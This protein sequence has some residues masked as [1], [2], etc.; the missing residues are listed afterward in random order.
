MS[1]I[2][3]GHAA[4]F[5]MEPYSDRCREIYRRGEHV[6]VGVSPG[7]GYFSEQR[8]AALLAWANRVFTTV[9]TIV[10]DVSLVHTYQALGDAPRQARKT[11]RQQSGRMCRRISRAWEATGVV[12]AHQRIRLL[13]EFTAHPVYTRLRAQV[14]RA[15]VADPGCRQALHGATRTALASRMKGTEPTDGQVEEAAG[16]LVAEMPLCMDAPAILETPTSVNIY[17]QVL[18]II[19][20]MFAS[21]PLRPAPGQAF[22]VVRPADSPAPTPGGAQ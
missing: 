15:I 13:S 6:L 9:E 16:Y 4:M 17:H 7:N 14:E 18:P 12:P 10:P 5:V 11:A 2:D 22:A 3:E 20:I 1:K 21:A 19:P 8:L